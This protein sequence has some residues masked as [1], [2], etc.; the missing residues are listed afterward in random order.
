MK[1]PHLA[2]HHKSPQDCALSQFLTVTPGDMVLWT[3][4]PNSPVSLYIFSP[5]ILEGGM[6]LF[7][8]RVCLGVSKGKCL[9]VPT[10]SHPPTTA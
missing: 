3:L 8:E 10:V 5:P 1:K 6:I 7:L 2:I 4:R 9:G